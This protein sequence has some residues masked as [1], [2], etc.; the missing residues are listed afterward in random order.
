[1]AWGI[2][3][4]SKVS[5][6]MPILIQTYQEHTNIQECSTQGMEQTKRLISLWKAIT[7]TAEYIGSNENTLWR[8]GVC[9]IIAA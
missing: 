9:G 6:A 5:D 2:C 1:M 4:Y 8:G 7:L 3:S